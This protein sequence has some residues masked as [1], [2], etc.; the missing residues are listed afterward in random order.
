[1][2]WAPLDNSL[3][4][5]KFVI[6]HFITLIHCLNFILNLETQTRACNLS[7][8]VLL[9]I[10]LITTY[11]KHHGRQINN[12]AA[13]FFSFYGNDTSG[14][15]EPCDPSCVECTGSDK[16]DCLGCRDGYFLLKR[17]GICVHACPS[18][19]FAD[20]WDKVCQRCHSSCKTCES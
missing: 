16:T 10:V 9:H 18:D 5:S 12:R 15:C 14:T 7:F 20:T 3:Q 13:Y 8:T 19:H 6:W 2:L 4:C 11:H 17:K 1:M